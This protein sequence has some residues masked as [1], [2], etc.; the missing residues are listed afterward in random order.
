MC[1]VERS[2]GGVVWKTAVGK[3]RC[4]RTSSVVADWWTHWAKAE[5]KWSG[6]LLLGGAHCGPGPM[7]L[8]QREVALVVEGG[9]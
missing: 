9:D 5:A 6:G 1:V 2:G 7:M 3:G 4:G 8:L